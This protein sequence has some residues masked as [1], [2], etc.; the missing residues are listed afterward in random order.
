MPIALEPLRDRCVTLAIQQVK[1][2]HRQAFGLCHPHLAA[3][4]TPPIGTTSDDVNLR[5]RPLQP[6]PERA[7]LIVIHPK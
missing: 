7:R 5:D 6:L 3:T 2:L 4:A 1:G